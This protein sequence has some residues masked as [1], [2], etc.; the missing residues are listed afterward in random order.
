MKL[1]FNTAAI[2]TALCLGAGAAFA[3]DAAPPAPPTAET[4]SI[5]QVYLAETMDP[6]QVRCTK[7]ENG[8]D[9]CQIF[10]ALMN[11]A[12]GPV[13]EFNMFEIPDG[14]GAAAGAV[15]IVP[16]ET[17]LERGLIIQ[18]DEN[19]PR[20]Y[21]FD[22]CNEYGCVVRAGFTPEELDAMKAGNNAVLSIVAMA[23]PDAPVQLTLSLESF[24]TAIEKTKRAAQ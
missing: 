4:A 1:I 8:D 23:N 14:A 18:V 21:G 19:E 17:S 12:G 10:Q 9:P 13:A 15:I 22:F 24:S 5:G 3:Q 7:T 20:G 11:A 6:W 16:L 2:V